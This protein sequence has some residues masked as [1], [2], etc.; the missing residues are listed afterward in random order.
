[1]NNVTIFW[2]IVA[3]FF[4]IFELGSP[5]LFFFLSFF[6][7][8]L[9]AAVASY[10][11][12][13]LAQQSI[14]FFGATIISFIVLKRWVKKTTKHAL[15][16]NFYALQGKKGLI[17][18]SDDANN[19]MQVKVEGETWS[20]RAKD[21]NIFAVGTQVQVLQIRGSHLLVDNID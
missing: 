1:M 17:V 11:G 2:A 5:G 14:Y 8:S 15:T 18:K 4:L 10:Y 7:G 12:Y 19:V 3:L 21:G 13:S 20:A 16:T 6:G 9:V